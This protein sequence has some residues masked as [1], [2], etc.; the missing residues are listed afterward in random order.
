MAD[1]GCTIQ[2]AHKETQKRVNLLHLSQMLH[3]Q[4]RLELIVVK[5][6]EGN[7]LDGL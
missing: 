7:E 3:T 6:L 5:A 1:H 2:A 4:A